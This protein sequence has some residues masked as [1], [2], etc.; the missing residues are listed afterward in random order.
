MKSINLPLIKESNECIP[1]VPTCCDSLKGTNSHNKDFTIDAHTVPSKGETTTHVKPRSYQV[2]MFEESQ[3]GNIIIAMIWFLTP[4]VSLGSQQYSY[5]QSQICSS[6]IKFL[7]SSDNIDRWTE[8]VVWDSVLKNV[9]IVV[10]PYQ[11][12]L[13]ALTHGFVKFDS[14]ALLVIDEAHNC[15]K[16]N[17]GAKIMNTFYHPRKSLGLYVP[18]I[19][20]LSASPVM[21]SNPASLVRIENTLDSLSRTPTKTRIDLR[22]RVKLPKLIPVKYEEEFNEY[23][24]LS[25]LSLE[26]AVEDLKIEEDPYYLSLINSYDSRSER[27][28]QK[29]LIDQKTWCGDHLRSL[30]NISRRI[31]FELGPWAVD[32]YSKLPDKASSVINVQRKFSFL[33]SKTDFNLVS[34]V[35]SNVSKLAKESQELSGIWED[36][37]ENLEKK[38]LAEVLGRVQIANSSSSTFQGVTNVSDKVSKLIEILR[39]QEKGFSGI[40]FVQERAVVSCLASILTEHPLCRGIVRVG[41][42]VGTSVYSKRSASTFDLIDTDSQ[43]NALQDF[44]SGKT[45]LLIGTSVLEEGIDIPTCNLVLCFQR[46]ANLKSYIQRRGRA[47]QKESRLYLLLN[48]DRDELGKFEQLEAEMRALYEDETRSLEET[49]LEAENK[50]DLE[51]YNERK[52]QI[53]KTDAILDLDN[54]LSHLYHFCATIPSDKYVD[55]RPE[56]ISYKKKELYHASI[57]LPISVHKRIRTAQ[58]SHVWKSEKNAI[59]DAAFE[60][61]VALYKAGLISD[62]LLPLMRYSPIDDS[63]IEKRPSMIKVQEQI[64]PWLDVAKAW[65]CNPRFIF[66]STVN[67]DGLEMYLYLPVKLPMVSDMK[68]YWDEDTEFIISIDSPS[69]EVATDPEILGRL[70]EETTTLIHSAFPLERHRNDEMVIKFSANK[71]LSHKM[72]LGHQ[73]VPENIGSLQDIGIIRDHQDVGYLFK[74]LLPRKPNAKDVQKANSEFIYAPND[75]PYL[76]LSRISRRRDFMHPILPSS[77][78]PSK[79]LYSTVLPITRCR[80]DN[81]PFKLVRF[82]LMIPSIMR[83]IELHLIADNISKNQLSD[84]HISDVSMLVS[85]VCTGSASE[86]TNYQRLEFLGDNVLKFCASIQV[87]AENPMWHEGQISKRKDHLVANSRLARTAIDLGIDKF[88]VT[89]SFTGLKWQPIYVESILNIEENEK[90]DLSSK[91]LADIVESILGV[92]MLDGG[93]S[94][95]ITCLNKFLP[96][97]DWKLPAQHRL[98]IYEE[99]PPLDLSRQPKLS[100]GVEMIET[101]LGYNFKKHSLLIEALT[102]ASDQSGSSSFE[103]LEFLGDAI[104]DYIVVQEMYPYDLSHIRMHE[105]RTAFV[106]ADLLAF[107]C[108]ELHSN[109]EVFNVKLTS[110]DSNS[111]DTVTCHKSSRQ[112]PLYCFMRHNSF[113]ISQAQKNTHERFE[114]L[115]NEIFNALDTGGEYPWTALCGLKAEKFFS[116]MIEAL[117]AAVWVDSGSLDIVVSVV[118]RMGILKFLR[119]AILENVNMEHPKIKLGKLADTE[120]V[121]YKFHIDTETDEKPD[122]IC[123]V[124]IG[125]VEV[126]CVSGQLSKLELQ[127]RGAVEAIKNFDIFLEV[128][129]QKSDSK[130]PIQSID[131]E[132]TEAENTIISD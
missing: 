83:N 115:R 73:N 105:L 75:V 59:R 100:K 112:I 52:F 72:Q 79:A 6:E 38:Y 23:S 111:Q 131:L 16:K 2:E 30:L 101:L 97:L 96:E 60:T 50:D 104:L 88:I 129:K 7:S 61:Y 120:T 113:A 25:F 55:T 126:A 9:D 53:E 22:Q 13:D 110:E 56:F 36:T 124:F 107:L 121:R 86:T 90:R 87:M 45:N 118:E 41:K 44:R 51:A 82:A 93:I 31:F 71:D 19:L 125:D 5:I 74:E 21:G 128:K 32:Y 28:L 10:S 43:N 94:K 54:A 39:E 27:K 40:V 47:R 1:S 89:K 127:T 33:S 102:H 114:D 65:S 15:V 64:N 4:T 68:V 42:F 77:E 48:S 37:L 46:P 70:N 49:P 91:V 66:Q 109:R 99:A 63:V 81:I 12:L 85:A 35:I 117:L 34:R 98:S 92:A 26:T 58:G 17:P 69:I 67:F 24:S 18:H 123:T 80:M 78:K 84:A 119:R 108:F 76:S 11:I 132:G 3:K 103:R 29:L 62:N 116:D 122:M 130:D 14:L 20:G 106:N 95:V 57:I 8:Q